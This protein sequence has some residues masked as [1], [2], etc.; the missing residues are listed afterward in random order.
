MDQ[1]SQTTTAL[2]EYKGAQLQNLADLIAERPTLNQFLQQGQG[3]GVIEPYLGDFLK[4]AN[5]NLI[6]LSFPK[7][8]VPSFMG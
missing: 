6:L 5:V 3:A 7:L 4:N 2:L 8:K 1:S